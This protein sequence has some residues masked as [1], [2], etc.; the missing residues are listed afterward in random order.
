M[1]IITS[2]FSSQEGLM[3]PYSDSQTSVI[4]LPHFFSTNQ[5]VKAPVI[6]NDKAPIFTIAKSG[7]YFVE[8]NWGIYIEPKDPP[9]YQRG[10]KST[11]PP[12]SNA[13]FKFINYWRLYKGKK[14]QL[15]DITN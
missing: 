11:K 5:R 2:H 7:I 10:L 6:S 9:N 8:S 14:E 12:A 1:I 3:L 4:T 13:I 15:I